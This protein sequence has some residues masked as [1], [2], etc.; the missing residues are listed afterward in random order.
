MPKFKHEVLKVCEVFF[1][2]QGEGPLIGFPTFFIRLFGCNLN[3]S[4]CDT[5]YAKPPNEFK[6]VSIKEIIKVWQNTSQS[7]YVTITGGE[8]LIQENVYPLIK[9]LISLGA[10]VSLETNGSIKLDKVPKEVIKVMDVKTP[11]SGMDKFNL[12]E[13]FNYLEKKDAIKFVIKDKEDFNFSIEIVKKYELLYKA[14]VIFSPVYKELEPGKLAR[15]I[16]ETRLPIRM[17]IQL[18]KYLNLC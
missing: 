4:W 11:S 7:P 10:S 8:P 14:Q 17:Q 6:E 12:Y 18:H 1:S 2:I 16:L 13:N 5:N 15:W 3:C 9:K